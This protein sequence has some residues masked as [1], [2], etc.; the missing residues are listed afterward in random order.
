MLRFLLIPLLFLLFISSAFTQDLFNKEN[1]Y[2]FARHLYNSRQYDIATREFERVLFMDPANDEAK[3]LLLQS[4]IASENYEKALV[5]GTLLYP[6][7]SEIPQA[8][9]LE[10]SRLLL[11]SDSVSGL[12]DLINNS[13]HL[14]QSDKNKLLFFHHLHQKKWDS[15]N[16]QFESM[17]EAEKAKLLSFKIYSESYKQ[18]KYKSAAVATALSIVMPGLGKV[19][20]RDWKDAAFSFIAIGTSAFQSYRGFSLYGMESKSGWIFGG[21]STVFYA[22]N[23]Y[24]SNKAAKKYNNRLNSNAKK[25]FKSL[26]LSNF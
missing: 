20:T 1:S 24:G 8:F 17:T 23:I 5:K 4:V 19:Y 7:I 26:L 10:Y 13:L 22:G 21:I 11:L 25:H 6:E 2:L 18:Q 15:A 14:S 12:P 16:S 3:L 9:A